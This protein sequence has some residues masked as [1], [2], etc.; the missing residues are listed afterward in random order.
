MI[1]QDYRQKLQKVVFDS[2]DNSLEN[3]D[4]PAKLASGGIDFLICDLLD[5]A[6]VVFELMPEDF[7]FGDEYYD[8]LVSLVSTWLS[9]HPDDAIDPSK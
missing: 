2:L 7:K 1:T 4:H 5:C 9:N 8:C 3:G 6:N